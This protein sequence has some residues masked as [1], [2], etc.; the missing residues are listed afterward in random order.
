MEEIKDHFGKLID[1]SKAEPH[2]VEATNSRIK[3]PFSLGY[4]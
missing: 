4:K 2:R 1:F 3:L